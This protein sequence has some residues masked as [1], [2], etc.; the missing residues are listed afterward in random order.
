MPTP[1]M[2]VLAR[3]QPNPTPTDEQKAA[4]AAKLA[5]MTAAGKTNGARYTVVDG[6]NPGEVE[7]GSLVIRPFATLADAQEWGTFTIGNGSTDLYY[8]NLVS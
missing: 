3:F 7:P 2:T 1:T 6:Y 5:E 4:S 8:F